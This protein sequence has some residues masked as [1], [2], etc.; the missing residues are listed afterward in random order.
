MKSNKKY[1][2]SFHCSF[3][4]LSVAAIIIFI[5]LV[6]DDMIKNNWP[7]Q[8]DKKEE[9]AFWQ[10]SDKKSYFFTFVVIFDF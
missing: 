2:G 1:E 5:R 4:Y 7:E 8:A 3:I 9:L 10:L 6:L